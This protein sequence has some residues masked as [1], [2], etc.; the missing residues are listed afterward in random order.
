MFLCLP[1][2]CVDIDWSTWCIN[3]Y[4]WQNGILGWLVARTNDCTRPPVRLHRFCPTTPLA[5]QP[6]V[7][8]ISLKDFSRY[9]PYHLSPDM[10]GVTSHTQAVL[11]GKVVYMCVFALGSVWH[12]K[13]LQ[14]SRQTETVPNNHHKA[15]RLEGKQQ[16]L[17]M[18]SR[19]KH[20]SFC[21]TWKD[22]LDN[23]RKQN[24]N[25]AKTHMTYAKR[26]I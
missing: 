13:W 3:G 5:W 24:W 26:S 18:T 25:E 16:D 7:T 4:R 6:H 23:I 19:I 17:I 21:D 10:T 22:P 20:F 1:S 15:C 8:Q 14:F 2:V 12:D 9:P 11:A